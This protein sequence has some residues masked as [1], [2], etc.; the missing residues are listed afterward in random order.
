VRIAAKRFDESAGTNAAN[1]TTARP[2]N[3]NDLRDRSL[4]TVFRLLL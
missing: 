2:K 4:R 3:T 1:A